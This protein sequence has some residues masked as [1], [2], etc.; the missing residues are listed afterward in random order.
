[1]TVRVQRVDEGYR[2]GGDWE[3]LDSA[4]AFLTHLAGRGFSAATVRAY[5]FDVANLARFLTERDVTLSEVQAPLVFDWIDWQGYAAPVGP[6][7][8]QLQPRR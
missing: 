5:A 2:L 7:R 4:N 1:M 6:S 3:G 8:A